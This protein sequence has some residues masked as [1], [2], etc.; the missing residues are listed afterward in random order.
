MEN[1]HQRAILMDR[2]VNFEE[3][4]LGCVLFDT[5]CIDLVMSKLDRRF[6]SAS[7]CF[8]IPVHAEIFQA[9]KNLYTKGEAAILP[10][11]V[12][13]LDR[14]NITPK[15]GAATLRKHLANFLESVVHSVNID[16]YI[17]L[18]LKNY[19]ELRSLECADSIKEI[20]QDM[21]LPVDERLASVRRIQDEIEEISKQQDDECCEFTGSQLLTN[22]IEYLADISSASLPKE[23]VPT[24][25]YDLNNK[26]GGGFCPGDLITFAGRPGMGKSAFAAQIGWDISQAGKRVHFYTLEM[27]ARQMGIRFL[28][29]LT[30]IDNT[31]LRA[32]NISASDWEKISKVAGDGSD[33]FMLNTSVDINPSRVIANIKKA[34]AR[35]QKPDVVI[36]DYLQLLTDQDDERLHQAIAEITRRLKQ[37]ALSMNIVVIVLSQLN[38]SVESRANKRPILSDL[39]GSGGIEQDCNIV[40]F[41]Y[42][43]EYY[44]RDTN[45]AGIVE[46]DIAKNRDG[47]TGVV[48]M[49]F[50]A[51]ATKFKNKYNPPH[52]RAV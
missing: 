35:D 9:M 51:P 38:R 48:E 20:M 3:T 18:M 25:F 22:T 17:K 21:T 33:N 40:M 46:V 31:L 12:R 45:A 50:D 39:K 14:M 32:G 42:R 7:T 4:V 15:R 27:T 5:G 19:G 47:S 34:A 49:L 41:L 52:L 16:E 43:D 29:G 6:G 11:V 10:A 24:N 8:V 23:F 30:D 1:E 2:A 28:S 36:I 26:L 37:I 13:E 44:D